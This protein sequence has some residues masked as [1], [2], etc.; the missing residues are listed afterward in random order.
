MPVIVESESAQ[1]AGLTAALV[2]TKITGDSKR[3]IMQR[4][5]ALKLGLGLIAAAITPALAAEDPIKL[6]LYKDALCGC[7]GAYAD[8]L[9]RNG[10]A[11]TVN[12]TRDLPLMNRQYGVP[13]AFQSCHLATVDR[14]F[15]E[16]HVPIDVIKRLLAEKPAVTGITLPGMPEGSPGM[17]GSKSAPFKIYALGD[18]PPKLYA[19]D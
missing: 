4:R 6:T 10:F 7:C 12:E 2:P 8:Y 18:G 5:T 16:G 1:A 17:G 15:V 14:Y 19:I 3:F 9:R 13:D 11:V